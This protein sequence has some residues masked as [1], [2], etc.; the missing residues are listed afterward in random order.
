MV[1]VAIRSFEHRSSLRTPIRQIECLDLIR[2]D[3]VDSLEAC[4]STQ[5][6]AFLTRRGAPLGQRRGDRPLRHAARAHDPDQ[7]PRAGARASSSSPAR[8]RGMRLTVGGRAPSAPHA[9]RAVAVARRGHASS[10]ASCREGRVGELLDRR[11]ARD[12]DVRAAARPPSLPGGRIPNVHLIV[13]TGH[14]EEV[15]ELVLRERGAD[16]PRPRAAA[17]LDHEHSAVR[18]RDRARRRPRPSLLRAAARSRSA[19]WPPSG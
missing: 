11:R 4:C 17:R 3:R 15:L 16:R 6:E 2:Y 9:Q 19:S 10:C 7:E 8:S 12:L 14:S 18:G 5:I 1:A 13:R